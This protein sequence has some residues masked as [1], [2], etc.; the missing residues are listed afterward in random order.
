MGSGYRQER[1]MLRADHIELACGSPR[2]DPALAGVLVHQIAAKGR[3]AM[4]RR[5]ECYVWAVRGGDAALVPLPAAVWLL[6]SVLAGLLSACQ[7]PL[8]RGYPV[9]WPELS[10]VSSDGT[11]INGTYANEGTL[12]TAN[13][14]QK[15]ITLASLVPAQPGG[16]GPLKH[17]SALFAHTEKISLTVRNP[18]K[19]SGV[20]EK[21]WGYTKKAYA[22]MRKLEFTSDTEHG[23]ESVKVDA[24]SLDR[25]DKKDAG[26]VLQYAL[27]STG[28]S[29][30]VVAGGSVRGIW[31]TKAADGSLIAVLEETDAYVVFPLIPIFSRSLAWARFPRVGT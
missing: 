3:R 10:V 28:G 22:S 2:C 13:G 8:D 21:P 16:S 20:S 26:H 14:E 9:S 19:E 5:I 6:L 15:P 23:A 18:S 24:Y 4:Q 25:T 1:L 11:E 27:E 7:T 29:L 30:G 31:L 12:T 17:A